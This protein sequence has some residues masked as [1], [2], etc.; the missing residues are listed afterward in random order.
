M[1]T[2]E[3][4]KLS[5]ELNLLEVLETELGDIYIYDSIIM[6]EGKENVTMSFRTGIFILLK[7]INLVKTR[8]VVYISHRI[9][10]YAVDPN[11]YKYLEMI[12][13]LK[14]IALVSYSDHG[15]EAAKFEKRFFK[16][17]FKNFRCLSDAQE[18]AQNVL[19]GIVIL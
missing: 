4:P 6:M 16:K 13:N 14:G 18:W 17:P 5:E 3:A 11:D 12:P 1:I 9:N 10:S 8:P 7:L 19:N 2:L 15:H